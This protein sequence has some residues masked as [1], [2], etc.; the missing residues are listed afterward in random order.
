MS[1]MPIKVLTMLHINVV[2]VNSPVATSKNITNISKSIFRD[3]PSSATTVS[4]VKG[5]S[6]H[7]FYFMYIFNIPFY[8][9]F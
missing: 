2:I 6:L 3:L 8:P 9:I 7:A 4:F 5:Y 1:M